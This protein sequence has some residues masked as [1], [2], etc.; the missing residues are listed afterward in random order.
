MQYG[1]ANGNYGAKTGT[2]LNLKCKVHR[3]SMGKIQNINS[4][5]QPWV[6]GGYWKTSAKMKWTSRI[7]KN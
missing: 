7:L 3:A 2:T 6:V 5:Q 4:P 1:M